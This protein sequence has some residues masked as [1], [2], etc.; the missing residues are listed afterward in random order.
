MKIIKFENLELHLDDSDTLSTKEVALGYG[1][2]ASTIRDHKKQH[3]D[4]ILK[5]IHYIEV[6]DEKFKRYIT[7]WTLEGVH[8]LGFFI[9]SERA[10]EFRKF[11][12]KLLTEIKKG[13]VHVSVAPANCPASDNM[14][15][16]ISG[17][18]GVIA[19]KNK[20]IERLRF[21]LLACKERNS[22]EIMLQHQIL[23][24]AGSLARE[25]EE[26]KEWAH[27]LKYVA[28]RIEELS[29]STQ[30][31][32]NVLGKYK[33]AQSN[34]EAQKKRTKKDM[35]WERYLLKQK[36]KKDESIS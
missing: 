12:A 3:Q 8:M 23:D 18:K 10:K 29:K 15:T 24:L 6:W 31:H 16:R 34:A 35:Q 11:T 22:K 9:K 30:Y 19:R 14:S 26:L 21:E 25:Q 1:V 7:R 4:E 5:N 33:N 13:N 20:E 32:L 36:S 27:H 17:Y 28:S 2:S